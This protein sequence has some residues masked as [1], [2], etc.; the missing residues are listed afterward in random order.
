MI[1]LSPSILSSDFSKLAEECRDVLR[2]GADWLHIDV[3]DGQFVPNLTLGAPILKSL[4]RSTPAFYDVHLMIREPDRYIEDFERAGADLITIHIESEGD[5]AATLRDI[6]ARGM[7]AGVTLR[8]GTSVDTILPLLPL[9][10]LAL[11]MTVEPGFGGQRFMED[12]L[13]KIRAIAAEAERL[14]KDGFY[15][16]VDGGIDA[17]TAPAAVAAGAN[18]LVAGSAIF[19]KPDRS[20]AIRALRAA[21][22]QQ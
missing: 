21:C 10:D 8:P 3:M 15:I 4:A 16:E 9:C 20:A 22:G 2:A 14:H 1:L 12:Q 11:V 13:P 7:K 19:G 5:A 17:D 6:R 18:V